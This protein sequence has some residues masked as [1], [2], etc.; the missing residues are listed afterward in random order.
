MR[1]KMLMLRKPWKKEAHGM[2]AQVPNPEGVSP[3][4]AEEKVRMIKVRATVACDNF[5]TIY[6]GYVG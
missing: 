6:R 5:F 3:Q 4:V 1:E 2:P